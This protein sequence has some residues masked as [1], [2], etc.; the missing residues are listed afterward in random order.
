MIKIINGKKYS[1][2]TAKMVTSW[3]NGYGSNDFHHYCE[4]LYLKKTG[5][6]FIEYSGG[7]MSRCSVSVGSDICGSSGI[8][9]LTEEETKEWIIKHCDGETYLELLGDVEE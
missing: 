6:Y 3:S 7:P 9:P 8:I 5:E 2:E 1:T 4:D